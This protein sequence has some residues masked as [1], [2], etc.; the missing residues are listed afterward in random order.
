MSGIPR[1]TPLVRAR[2][3]L[4]AALVLALAVPVGAQIQPACL[5][6]IDP[7]PTGPLARPGDGA[8]FP[9]FDHNFLHSSTHLQGVRSVEK[10]TGTL[11]Y[12]P[13]AVT[14]FQGFT[15][16]VIVDNPDPLQQ[17]CVEI[18]YFAEI[19]GAPIAT[20]AGITIAADGFYTEA[21]TPLDP[22]FGAA[23]GVGHARIRVVP[24]PDGDINSGIVGGV[25]LHTRD[26]FNVSD[27]DTPLSTQGLAPG[28][29]SMQQ[30]QIAQDTASTV[31]WG[32]VP[33]TQRSTADFHNGATPFFTV[34]NPNAAPTTVAVNYFLHDRNAGG[35][36]TGP[37]N[38]R[39]LTLPAFGSLTDFTGPHL[40]ALGTPAP[41][42]WN[43]INGLFPTALDLDIIFQFVSTDGLS[44][45]ADGVMTDVW[46]DVQPIPP[47]GGVNNEPDP[48]AEPVDMQLGTRFRMVSSMAND[49][50]DWL[51]LGP[52]DSNQLGT[53]ADLV[54]M[55]GGIANVGTTTFNLALQ[56][57]DRN[58]ALISVGAVALTPGQVTRIEP[59]SP[60]YPGGSNGFGW[61]RV[62]ACRP[63]DDLIG[64]FGHEILDE[65]P[66]VHYRK[67]FGQTF[68]GS[69]S[70]EPGPGFPV[71]DVSGTFPQ[72]TRKVAPIQRA[73][74]SF[75]WPGYVTAVNESVANIGQY[76]WQFF[77]NTGFNCTFGGSGAF[78]AGLPFGNAS[79]TYV[80]PLVFCTGNLVGTFDQESG[81]V[82]GIDVLGDP[83]DEWGIPGFAGP[84]TP[85][86]E[87]PPFP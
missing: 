35:L 48:N 24:C 67:A 85:G 45:V 50:P 58:G 34:V 26:L 11:L 46:G 54:R 31:W 12:R 60:G 21:A 55:I 1:S 56:Y 19:G 13:P 87:T 73:T 10:W 6:Q 86:D 79:T 61:L 16:A 23:R 17:A 82:E 80:D 39:T 33:V 9:A 84:F 78:F 3:T 22:A 27:P 30:L 41:G 59:G 62:R 72:L 65:P 71:A 75:P 49:D 7:Q 53:G 25:L 69:N 32:P 83:F 64:W 42:I 66:G 43:A 18:D 20:S 40:A 52:D 14:G 37:F 68:E 47:I 77:A 74:P 4:V 2:V 28:M 38:W 44:L 8:N 51:I 81:E 57:F 15:S 70:V 76:R 29:S 5:A 63:G 36:V